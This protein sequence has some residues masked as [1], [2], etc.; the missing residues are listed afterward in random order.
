M[1]EV[2]KRVAEE[3]FKAARHRGQVPVRHDDRAAPRRAHG[4]P[5]WPRPRSSSPSAPTTSPRPAWACPA[6]TPASSCPSTWTWASCP[7]SPSCPSTPRASGQLVQMACERGKKTRPDI[8]LGIC[9]EHGGDPGA[10]ILPRHAGPRLRVLLALPRAD[11]AP[12]GGAGHAEEEAWRRAAGPHGL[13]SSPTCPRAERR[14]C[15]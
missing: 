12:R 6:T 10:S 2:T 15:G 5:S 4:A 14:R 11:R 8:S 7:T 9:G 13:R 3:V 1:H